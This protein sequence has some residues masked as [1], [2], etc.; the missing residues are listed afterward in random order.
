MCVC[1]WGGRWVQDEIGVFSTNEIGICHFFADVKVFI[2]KMAKPAMAAY[3]SH[4]NCAIVGLLSCRLFIYNCFQNLE[5]A[6]LNFMEIN[7]S[8]WESEKHERQMS[9][10]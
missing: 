2:V 6:C 1:A 9:D 3:I 5:L 10:H 4:V 7:E 8:A